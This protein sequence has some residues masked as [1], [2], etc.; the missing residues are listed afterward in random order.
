MNNQ[1][2]N[3]LSKITI[4]DMKKH[5]KYQDILKMTYGK[6]SDEIKQMCYKIANEK[7]INLDNFMN[8]I[9]K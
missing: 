9:G 1:M 4:G 7:G 8:N 5:P 6:S 3:M 2:L